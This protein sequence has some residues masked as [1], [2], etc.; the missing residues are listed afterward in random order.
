[1]RSGRALPIRTRI[2]V[3]FAVA[4]ALVLAGVGVF[5]YAR[6]GADLLDAVDAG[7]RSRADV[8]V[9]ELRVSGSVASTEG[10][11]IERDEAFVQVADVTGAV[12][13][14]DAIVARHP[15][16]PPGTIR[17]VD[18]ATFYDRT[19]PGIDNVVR[20]LAVPVHL[21][22]TASFVLVGSSLQDRRDQLLQLGATL[23][24]GG[25]VGLVLIS[26]GAWLL[27]GAALRPVEAMRREAAAISALEPQ[28]R[29][30]VPPGDDE[31][32]AL[33]RT[34]NSMLERLE[35]VA[36]SE[37]RFVD[38]PATSS[39]RRSPSSA[40]A[41][42]SRCPASARRRSCARRSARRWPTP[43]TSRDCRRTCWS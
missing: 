22:G 3:A 40:R 9:A 8:V 25:A 16:L 18:R 24:V 20:V 15:L 41:S 31:M 14:S 13:R 36:S 35:D 38:E 12:V 34:L 6:T 10:P 39:E 1:M 11:L 26:L 32:S 33:A 19:V 4:L 21:D 17:D 7:L 37:H 30:A 43:S 2:T 23:A 5:V 29:L 28:Q 27:V 42:R